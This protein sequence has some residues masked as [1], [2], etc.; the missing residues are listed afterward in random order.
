MPE[1]DVGGKRRRARHEDVTATLI[2]ET[3][4]AGKL[5]EEYDAE[6]IEEVVAVAT[7]PQLA[8]LKPQSDAAWY[9]FL[10]DIITSELGSDRVDYLLRDAMHSGLTVG[11]FDYRKL[12]DSMMIVPPPEET[13]EG[14]RLGI[15][16]AGWLMAEHMVVARYLMYV[17]LYFHK[18]KRI[19]ELHLEEFLKKWLEKRYPDRPFL[20]VDDPKKYAHLTDSIVW[21]AIYEATQREGDELK[22]LATPFVDRS[23]RRLACEVV[24][25]DNFKLPAL[26]ALL[27]ELADG[28]E[29]KLDETAS[30]HIPESERVDAF[31]ESLRTMLTGRRP[32]VWDEKR[33]DRLVAA[34]NDYVRTKFSKSI[35]KDVTKHGAVKFFGPRDRIWVFLDGKTRYL[36]DLSEIVSGM[37]DKIWRGRIYT[38]KNIRNDVKS[39]CSRWLGDNGPATG[40]DDAASPC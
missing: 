5:K 24:L 20:P 25:A 15:D 18:T 12:I 2:R 34:A 8:N 19:Y 14:H 30:E 36:D 3:E 4:I 10:N 9:R 32:R 13:G 26:G 28:A 35:L 39:F 21:A 38:E 16:G 11:L 23:H 6:I 33:F 22:A 29:K 37:P 7:E 1:I 27:K 40:D 17:A 31:G